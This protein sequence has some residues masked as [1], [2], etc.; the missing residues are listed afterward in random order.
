MT[1]LEDFYQ[2]DGRSYV[3]CCRP[4]I[5]FLRAR[6]VLIRHRRRLHFH[7]LQSLCLSLCI[8]LSLSLSNLFRKRIIIINSPQ[9][10][11][12]SHFYA[13]LGGNKDQ[14]GM[15]LS[16]AFLAMFLMTGVYGK[17]IDSNGNKYTMPYIASF[18]FGIASYTIYFLAILIP[19]GPIAVYTLM[20]SRFLEG[21]SVAG[22]TLSYS[23]IHSMVPHDKQKTVLTTLSMSRTIGTIVGP[24]TNLLVTEIN[25]E[26]HIFDVTIPVNPNNSI[27]LLMVGSEFVLLIL[28]LIFLL[29]PPDKKN[30]EDAV[31]KDKDKQED[32]EKI[33]FLY[34]LGHIELW[35]VSCK[36][37]SIH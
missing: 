29:E 23:W 7:C 10:K 5:N 32:D 17:W 2:C 15:M 12:V 30:D 24:I 33:G 22:R 25:T 37:R 16:V 31:L 13:E 6:Y 1:F 11:I 28:T 36:I 20:F 35:Y 14:Y 9:T 8:T 26:W 27:G 3:G 18:V 34:A 4:D 21:M 19:P